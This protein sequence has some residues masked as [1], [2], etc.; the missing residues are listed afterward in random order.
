MAGGVQALCGNARGDVVVMEAALA[1][2]RSA[3]IAALGGLSSFF[4]FLMMLFAD[5]RGR[6]NGDTSTHQGRSLR[7]ISIFAHGVLWPGSTICIAYIGFKLSPVLGAFLAFAS[8]GVGVYT[9]DV[10]SKRFADAEKETGGVALA[11]I[12]SGLVFGVFWQGLIEFLT[13]VFTK[14]VDVGFFGALLALGSIL[15][16]VVG[17]GFYFFVAAPEFS[18][19]HL[20]DR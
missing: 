1:E 20:G 8:F 2:L 3:P 7:Q 16:T 17:T 15:G 9:L 11:A 18:R 6:G 5:L 13:L 10:Q 4:A 19:R 12:V 14:Y